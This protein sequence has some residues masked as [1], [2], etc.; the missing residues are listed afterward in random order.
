M[1]PVN[2]PIGGAGPSWWGTL[3]PL[4]KALLWVVLLLALILVVDY[5]L[6]NSARLK[7]PR[8]VR[9]AVGARRGYGARRTHA[10]WDVTG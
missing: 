3:H 7:C 2:P 5:I 10:P 9:N 8:P 1:R 4:V 6:R